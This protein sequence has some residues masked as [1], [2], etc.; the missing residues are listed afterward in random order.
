MLVFSSETSCTLRLFSGGGRGKENCKG[1]ELLILKYSS[2]IFF[3]SILKILGE[4][5]GSQMSEHFQ[6]DSS[7][8]KQGCIWV[9]FHIDEY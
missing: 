8:C 9:P 3:K 4:R 5:E 2:S 1:T 7:L 6:A